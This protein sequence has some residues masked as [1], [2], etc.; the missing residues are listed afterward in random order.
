MR[1]SLRTSLQCF[2]EQKSLAAGFVKLLDVSLDLLVTIFASN[3]RIRSADLA[4]GAV[5]AVSA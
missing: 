3:G 4:Y 2:G 1:M 5:Y